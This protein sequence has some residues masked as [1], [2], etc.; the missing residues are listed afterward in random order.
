MTNSNKTLKT[1]FRY[2]AASILNIEVK[3]RSADPQKRPL[4]MNLIL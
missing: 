1:F 3:R 4:L 2:R